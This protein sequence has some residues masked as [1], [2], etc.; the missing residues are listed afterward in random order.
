MS[1]PYKN[2]TAEEALEDYKKL[3]AGS[4]KIAGNKTTDYAMYKL[5]ARTK[6]GKW[7]HVSAWN[8]KT[9]RAKIMRADGM[10]NKGKTP[11]PAQ[12]R[13][14]LQMR[15]GSA[16]QFKAMFAKK[17]YNQF[18]PKRV[19]DFSSGWGGRMLGAIATET[20]YIGI[21]SNK[22]LFPAYRKILKLLK[23]QVH[24]Q[25][26]LINKYSEN[27]DFSKMNYDMV[28]TSPPYERVEVYENM[29]DYSDFYEQF[30]I[31]VLT[32]TWQHLNKGGYY[33]LNIPKNMLAPSKKVLGKVHKT[34]KYPI[35]ER[36]GGGGGMRHENIYVWKK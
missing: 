15:Y 13:G 35:A 21:D 28:F 14:T 25:V 32:K 9:E 19:L 11:T 10:L 33:L 7:S 29:K 24:S 22:A 30:Y 23:G 8:D 1:F 4:N 34:I 5:R 2:I 16:N 6:V 18:K 3:L 20:D 36:A 27:V 26:R 31:P 17:I 12:L